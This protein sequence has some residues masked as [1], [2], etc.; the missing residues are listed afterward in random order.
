MQTAEICVG[1][2]PC[3]ALVRGVALVAYRERN[4]RSEPDDRNAQAVKV[5]T[6]AAPAVNVALPSRRPT[7]SPLLPYN[8]TDEWP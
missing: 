2:R 5:L 6:K 4:C 3:G 7:S 1:W 8:A